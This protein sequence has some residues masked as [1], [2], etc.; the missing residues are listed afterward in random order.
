MTGPPKRLPPAH[1]F[2]LDEKTGLCRWCPLPAEH[3]AV[4]GEAATEA[5]AAERDGW[6]AHDA[7]R[8]GERPE[9]PQ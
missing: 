6:K 5:A 3:Q 4:H 8:V 1:P 2:D 9:R 7:R